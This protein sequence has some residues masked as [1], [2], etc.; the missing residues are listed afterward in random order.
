M[1]DFFHLECDDTWELQTIGSR[2]LCLKHLGTGTWAEADAWCAGEGASLILPLNA[3]ENNEFYSYTQSFP[4][5]NGGWWLDGI[6][7]A[8]EGTWR[9]SAGDLITYFNWNSG[10]PD[11]AGGNEHYLHYHGPFGK[12]WNDI[13]AG[14]NEHAL[15]QKP[16]TRKNSCSETIL[17]A[18]SAGVALNTITVQSQTLT[19]TPSN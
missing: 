1:I 12:K 7:T 9:T 2:S 4:D 6:D 8:K 13:T 16:P 14:Y 17:V 3:Q 10:Q 19:V 5:L 18:S 15:C 11:N